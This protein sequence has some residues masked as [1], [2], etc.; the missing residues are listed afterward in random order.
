MKYT[1]FLAF[2]ICRNCNLANQ[3]TRCPSDKAERWANDSPGGRPLTDTEI[4][5]CIGSAYHH[6][7]FHGNVAWHY[8]NE[9]MLAWHR[10]VALMEAARLQVLQ[11]KFT[12]WTNGTLLDP[13]T[14]GLDLLDQIW[15]SNYQGRDFTWLRD[16]VPRVV[17]FNGELDNRLARLE[18]PNENPCLRPFNE[19]VIDNHGNGR[20]CC[21][22]W[23]GE[24]KL[25]NVFADGFAAVVENYRELRA[26][27][28]AR[29]WS[30]AVPDVC[31]YCI[32]RQG[33]IADLVSSVQA[34]TIDHIYNLRGN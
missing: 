4:V 7:G 14:T 28:A 2:E 32:G 8:Y 33:C 23:R 9:P 16:R 25:G 15:I 20:L 6:L 34:E 27:V 1:Q 30:P 29:P 24:A 26:L 3:H 22:D 17:V 21:M 11:A 31:R 5:E 18:T 12:L 10:L 13:Y 19:L